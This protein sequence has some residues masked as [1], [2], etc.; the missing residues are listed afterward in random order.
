MAWMGIGVGGVM[1]IFG[2]AEQSGWGLLIGGV[3]LVAGAIMLRYE[4]S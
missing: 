2:I 4:E 1:V 3:L